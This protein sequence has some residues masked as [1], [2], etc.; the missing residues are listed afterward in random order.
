MIV[1]IAAIDSVKFSSKS[2]LS[3]R[4]LGCLKFSGSNFSETLNG[5]LPLEDGSD[6]CET[7]PKRVSDDSR[8]LI[9]RRRNNFFDEIFGPK[10]KHQIKNRSF[11][12]SHEFLSVNSRFSTKNDPISPEDQVSPFL[13]EGVQRRFSIFLLTFGPKLTY[14]FR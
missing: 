8:H 3:S 5:R 6:R 14:T 13:G 7:L 4:F 10:M 9:F 2:E 12:R 11:W 1:F